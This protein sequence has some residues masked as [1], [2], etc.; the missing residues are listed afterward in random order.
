MAV[1]EDDHNGRCDFHPSLVSNVYQIDPTKCKSQCSLFLA[2]I[3]FKKK[4]MA[5]F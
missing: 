2:P 5:T 1:H 4:E 3:L